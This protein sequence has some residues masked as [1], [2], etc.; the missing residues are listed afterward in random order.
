MTFLGLLY[1]DSYRVQ[2]LQQVSCSR[3]SGDIPSR[4]PGRGS[5][6]TCTGNAG[7]QSPKKQFFID[8][9]YFF[10][11]FSK[12]LAPSGAKYREKGLAV[13]KTGEG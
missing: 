10:G 7:L 1:R 11:R 3:T 2:S 4:C 12:Y 5:K 9:L 8:F 6:S 13:A